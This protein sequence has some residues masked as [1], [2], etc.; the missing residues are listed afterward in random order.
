MNGANAVCIGYGRIHTGTC[1]ETDDVSCCTHKRRQ[2]LQLANGATV[3]HAFNVA[4]FSVRSRYLH[5]THTHTHTRTHLHPPQ[6]VLYTYM[7]CVDA[8]R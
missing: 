5:H 4:P 6:H 2:F 7:Y 3:V 1:T 8:D